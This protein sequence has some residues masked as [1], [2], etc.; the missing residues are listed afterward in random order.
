MT[1]QTRYN[2]EVGIVVLIA[3]GLLGA[4]ITYL[5]G[6]FNYARTYTFN[7]EFRDARGVTVSTPVQMSG[8]EIGRVEEVGLTPRNTARLR[9]RI[10][11]TYPIPENARFLIATGL[12]ASTAIVKVDPTTGRPG[13]QIAENQPGLVGTEAP[14]LD[15]AFVQGQRVLASAENISRAIERLVTDPQ[16]QRDLERTRR[17][18]TSTAENL[19]RATQS[20]PRL[21]RDIEQQGNLLARQTQDIAV[22]LRTASAS[23]PRLARQV[24]GL[25]GDVRGTLNENRGALR[26]SAQNIAATTSAV[27]GLTEQ[28]SAGLRTGNLRE[29]LAATTSNLRQISDRFVVISSNLERLSSDPRLNSDVREIA[30]NARDAS[31][32]LRNLAARIETIRI[33]GER[34]PRPASDPGAPPA[35]RPAPAESLLEPGL[36][37]SSV[38]EAAGDSGGEDRVRLDANYTLL[39]LDG[40]FYRLGLFDV[41]ERNRLDLQLGQ[42]LAGGRSALRYGLIHG[43]LGGGLDTRLGPLFLRADLYQPNRPTLDLRARARLSDTTSALVGLDSVGRDNRATV[44]VQF[45]R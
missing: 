28:L 11:N 44:G 42:V 39:G 18:L 21:A 12:L 6:T 31:T 3:L 25:T 40:R 7:V 13:T 4:T 43:K 26:E 17:S 10:N 36:S 38:F 5:K 34:R 16:G 15:A 35:P 20:L 1:R 22:N 41:S 24:E 2:I 30:T 37:L 14:S 45:I 33:P 8:V 9:L 19:S 32:S 27:R 29:D 23:A